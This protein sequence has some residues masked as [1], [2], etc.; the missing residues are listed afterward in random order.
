MD[1]FISVSPARVKSLIIKDVIVKTEN[2][3]SFSST[4]ELVWWCQIHIRYTDRP[5]SSLESELLKFLPIGKNN[6][7]AVLRTHWTTEHL[8][9]VLIDSAV[10]QY[11]IEIRDSI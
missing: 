7:S 3:L 10:I 2:T 1:V 8:I 9:P 4:T 6:L 5:L 11:N